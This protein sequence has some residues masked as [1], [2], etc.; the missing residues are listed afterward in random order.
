MASFSRPVPG[1]IVASSGSRS[2]FPTY[3]HQNFDKCVEAAKETEHEY[4]QAMSTNI[5]SNTLAEIPGLGLVHPMALT[6]ANCLPDR[7]AAITRFADFTIL[8]DDYYDSAKKEEIQEVNDGIQSAIR[9]FSSPSALPTPSSSS[10]FKAKQLQAGFMLELFSLDQEFAL[11]IMSSY[12][13]GL[14]IATFAPDDLKT[15]DDYLPVRSIN[16][17]LD[18][19]ED[20]ACFGTG[21][22]IS[23]AEKEKL[24]KATD[25]AKYAITIVNDLYSWPK[26]IKCHLETPGSNPPFNAVA[27]LMRHSGYSESEAF[28]ALADKQAELEDK[29]LRL[30]EALREQEG[31]SL[32]ENQERYIA[33][34]QQAVSGSELWSVFTTRYP[35]KADLQQPPVEF[36]DGKLRYAS[37]SSSA[38]EN[39]SHSTGDLATIETTCDS[40]SITACPSEKEYKR[41]KALL[42]DG[43]DLSTYA[44]RVAAAPDHPV[45]APFKY[46][47]SLPSKGVRD[48]F[49]D[50]LNWWLKVPDD[51]LLSIKTVISMLHDSSLMQVEI[52]DDIED[53]STLRRGSPAAHTIYGTA[54]CINA[55]N[56]MVVM[57]LVEIQKLRSPRK[58]DILSEELEN[59]FLGQSEDLFWK[60]QVECPTT[61]EYMEMIENKTGGLFRLCVRLLQ[62]ES[63]RNDVRNLDPRPFV[64]QLSLYF[65]IRDDYQN[66]VSDQYAKQKGFAEDLDEGKISLP[67]ILTLQRMRTRPE[68]MGIMKHKKPGPMSMEMKQFIL[69]EMRKSGALET[70]HSLLQT[71]QED[72][73][74]ELRGLERDFGSKNPMLE[75]VLRKLWIS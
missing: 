25:M 56:Y 49:I 26:E 29:H 64:R 41:T 40:Q 22:R 14:D 50:A 33:N 42:P 54:Q 61:E 1:A 55:A 68:I 6:I 72:L 74:T 39:K 58:L 12:S 70:T 67:M 4:N 35:S 46:I 5:K 69:T 27:V 17:G 44:S 48:T 43:S 9:G 16:S 73:I 53:D 75:M 18:V 51:S 24:R 52:L 59:L 23:R 28:Q 60:Y 36:V 34:A 21:V 8:N 37:S 47:A 7:L 15:L 57:V 13:Q 32:P 2:Q 19:T 3:I 10:A 63:T 20:M 71:M 65:Q 11:H 45:M 62:A 30:V 31:G 38:C 66:L